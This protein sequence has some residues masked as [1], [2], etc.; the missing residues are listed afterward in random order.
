[1]TPGSSSHCTSPFECRAFFRCLIHVH[2][3][4]RFGGVFVEGKDRVLHLIPSLCQRLVGLFVFGREL[5]DLAE[6]GDG[7]GVALLAVLEYT[8]IEMSR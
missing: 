8:Q 4:S 6:G 5:D 3:R 2:A 7:L 1:M